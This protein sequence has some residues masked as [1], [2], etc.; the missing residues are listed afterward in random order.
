MLLRGPRLPPRGASEFPTTTLFSSHTHD[1][2]CSTPPARGSINQMKKA[3][4]VGL[5]HDRGLST[6]A[7]PTLVLP[8]VPVTPSSCGGHTP[9]AAGLSAT[10]RPLSDT[11]THVRLSPSPARIAT[12]KAQ[13]SASSRPQGLGV[14]VTSVTLDEVVA[15]RGSDASPGV[16]PKVQRILVR[17]RRDGRIKSPG[18]PRSSDSSVRTRRHLNS[19]PYIHIYIYIN[20]YIYIPT[21]P[22]KQMQ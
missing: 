10:W 17:V 20:I 12:R 9:S 5:R 3:A 13:H 14:H 4:G 21:A 2:A 18:P 15:L 7:Q 6:A 1:P 19:A 22:E 11:A 16:A 8:V